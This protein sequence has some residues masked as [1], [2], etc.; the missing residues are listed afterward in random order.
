VLLD[1]VHIA[2][3]AARFAGLG[4]GCDGLLY[5]VSSA[6]MDRLGVDRDDLERLALSAAVAV[7]Q[8]E[9]ELGGGDEDDV[10]PAMNPSP[11]AGPPA[12]R[13]A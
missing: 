10:S 7:L 12:R 11:T 13:T 5:P 6:A 3:A 4:L 2:D 9:A 8:L 1:V